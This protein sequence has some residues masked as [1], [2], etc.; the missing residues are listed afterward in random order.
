MVDITINNNKKYSFLTGL[1]KT[2]KNVLIMFG[3][4]ILAFLANVPAEYAVLA[5]AVSYMIKNYI[6]NK[7]N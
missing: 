5:G 1:K 7:D 6:E 4:A 2:L 3:P